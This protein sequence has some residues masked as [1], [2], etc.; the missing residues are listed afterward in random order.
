MGT[1]LE[2]RE[3]LILFVEKKFGCKPKTPN[4]FNELILAVKSVTGKSLSL[5]TVKRLWGY[6]AYESEPSQSTLSILSRFIG[7]SGWEDFCISKP[8]ED[9]DLIH[10]ETTLQHLQHGA[11]VTLEWEPAK[12]CTLRHLA[13]NRFIV[14]EAH[15]IKLKQGDE[16]TVEILSTGQP[17]YMKDIIRNGRKIPLYIAAKKNGLKTIR[18]QT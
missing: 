6:V 8:D 10:A 17:V 1:A 4:D 15:N 12:G 11:T 7:Y 16:L 2:D 14:T 3:K 9:S 13:S 5:S 18:F